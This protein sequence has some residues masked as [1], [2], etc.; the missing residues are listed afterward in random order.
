LPADG[1]GEAT[2]AVPGPHPEPPEDLHERQPTITESAGPWLRL[3]PIGLEPLY[4]N[5]DPQR[6]G[7][8]GAPEGEYGVLYVSEDEHGAFVET[9]GRDTGVRVIDETDLLERGLARIESSR[10]LRL[11]DLTGEGL[12]RIGADARLFAAD[13]AVA[14]R[15][16]AALREHHVKPDGLRYPCRH[17]PSRAAVALYDRA[18]GA[19]SASPLGTMLSRESRVLLSQILRAYDFS[20]T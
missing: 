6:S 19:L 9:I 10:L 17:D 16:S 7:R 11:V 2:D 14:R 18:E 8:F 20:L 5:Q 15:W 1:G 4:F 13:H 3:H 12:A